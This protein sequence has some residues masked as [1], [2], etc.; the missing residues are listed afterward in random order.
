MGSR[1]TGAGASTV[2]DAAQRFDA[3]DPPSD[4]GT[5]RELRCRGCG[6]G[7]IAAHPISR[8]PMC[9]GDDWQRATA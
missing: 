4:G 6:Y 9:G 5:R 8:C 7:A 3:A 2:I 1:D